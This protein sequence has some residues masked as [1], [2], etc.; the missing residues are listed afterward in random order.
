MTKSNDMNQRG[1]LSFGF[2]TILVAL[3]MI[4]IVTFSSLTLL[5]ANSDYKHSKEAAARAKAYSSAQKKATLQLQQIDETLA[6]A[7]SKSSNRT[8][9]YTLARKYL[10]AFGDDLELKDASAST[11][12]ISYVVS[13]GANTTLHVE[14]AVSYPPDNKECYYTLIHWRTL[15]TQPSSDAAQ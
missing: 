9:Y 6:K 14:L 4:C 11:L 15:T 5:T 7:Y 2:S 12:T 8:T 1:F 13:C 3:T 10:K